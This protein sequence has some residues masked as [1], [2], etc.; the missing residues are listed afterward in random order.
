LLALKEEVGRPETTEGAEKAIKR[1]WFWVK[2]NVPQLLEPLVAGDEADLRLTD[3]EF[4]RLTKIVPAKTGYDPDEWIDLPPRSLRSHQVFISCGQ[5]TTEEIALGREIERLV[6][7]LP[8]FRGYF[9]QN[10]DSPAGVTEHILRALHESVALICVMHHRGEVTGRDG[11]K[12]H[13]ASLWIEQ[14]IAIAAFIEQILN[15]RIPVRLYCENGIPVE[16][17]RRQIMVHALSFEKAQDILDDLREWLPKL[18][19]MSTSG[20]VSFPMEEEHR[21]IEEGIREYPRLGSAKVFL[22]RYPRIPS[23][24]KRRMHNLILRGGR[25][26]HGLTSVDTPEEKLKELYPDEE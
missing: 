19:D 17:I 12:S 9:A 15:R 26:A 13:R 10:Q 2:E 22:E 3:T 23:S 18:K 5:A 24:V 14:E 21:L 8:G 11:R 4:D 25:A 6:S 7:S 20:Q 1:L 16:G